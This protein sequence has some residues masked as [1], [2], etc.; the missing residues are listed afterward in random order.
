MQGN[1]SEGCERSSRVPVGTGKPAQKVWPE[2]E[3]RKHD[4]LWGETYTGTLETNW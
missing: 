2:Q 4:Q 3:F 1:E